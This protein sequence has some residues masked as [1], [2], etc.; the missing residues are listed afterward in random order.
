MNQKHNPKHVARER[1]NKR[2]LR[3]GKQAGKESAKRSRVSL[4]KDQ[5]LERLI[6]AIPFPDADWPAI[7]FADA[8][9]AAGQLAE[10]KDKAVRAMQEWGVMV[11]ASRESGI[12]RDSL[13]RHMKNDPVFR[14]R[15]QVA[16]QNNNERIE[17]EMRKRGQLKSGELAAIFVMKHNIK[18]YREIQRVE[19]TGKGGGPVGYVDAK[20][21]LLKRIEAMV[22]KS[23]E[24]DAVA[25]GGKPKLLK[26]GSSGKVEI[27][28]IDQGKGWNAQSKK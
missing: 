20:A 22:I 21:E 6:A 28:K 18:K 7:P 1:Q 2:L 12:G 8:D 25:V 27:R 4:E 13:R 10:A 9:V 5:L 26:G 11:E 23:R 17:R 15:M 24:P 19:L 3:D 16:L 14:R